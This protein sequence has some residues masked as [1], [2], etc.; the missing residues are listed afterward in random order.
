MT[1][2]APSDI[3]VDLLVYLAEMSAELA[4]LAE[5][6]EQVIPAY[7]LKLAADR[8]HEAAESARMS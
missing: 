3:A 1:N 7:H 8:L 2:D 6:I 5:R 4:L